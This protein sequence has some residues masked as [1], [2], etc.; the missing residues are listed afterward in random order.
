[1]FP[2]MESS[3]HHDGKKRNRAM[4]DQSGRRFGRLVAVALVEQDVSKENNH[5]W[6]FKCDCG[7]EKQAR[8]KGVRSGKTSSCGCFFSEMMATRNTKH[9]FSNSSATYRS[10]KDM[11]QRC[12]NENSGDWARYG[13]RGISVCQEWDDFLVFL[14]DMGERPSGL[15][16]DR[17]DVN[18]DYS[19][20][21]CRWATAKTQ[22]NNKTSN[23][24]LT[25]NGKT[26]TLQQWA[27]QTGIKRETIAARLRIGMPEEK[28]LHR[29]RLAPSSC[30]G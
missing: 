29:G 24:V 3:Q 23:K 14:S 18:G 1:M 19:K 30:I 13:G 20:E 28:I 26:Q 25:M 27:D 22:A 4:K 10:W 17:I 21:N 11:R 8:I 6:L 12:M 5:L 16:L 2:F 15:T 7:N 9:G